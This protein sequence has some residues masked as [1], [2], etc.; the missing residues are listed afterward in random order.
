MEKPT[1][2]EVMEVY[3]KT[4]ELMR[5]S[6]KKEDLEDVS[7]EFETLCIEFKDCGKKFCIAISDEG[8]MSILEEPL[9][10]PDCTITTDVGTMHDL[11]MG[12]TNEV[13][14]YL[15]GK[16]KIAGV[17]PLKIQKL[18]P[19]LGPLDE[20]YKKALEEVQGED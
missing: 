18:L 8:E 15:S 20:C 13:K 12:T 16:I 7:E 19:K 10:N 5:E 17:S 4:F 6:A 14:A 3:K 9:A 2:D 11:A 1:C